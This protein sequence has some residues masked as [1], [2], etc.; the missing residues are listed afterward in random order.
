VALVVLLLADDRD[1][2]ELG[3]RRMRVAAARKRHVT[4]RNSSESLRNYFAP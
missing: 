2:Q 1:C 4:E 3:A